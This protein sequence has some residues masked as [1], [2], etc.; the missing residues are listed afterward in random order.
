MR[1]ETSPELFSAHTRSVAQTAPQTP[2]RAGADDAGEADD[3]SLVDVSL[4]GSDTPRVGHAVHGAA[5]SAARSA[6]RLRA[7]RRRS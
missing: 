3:E 4:D 7:P 1:S 5:H 2:L 6:R